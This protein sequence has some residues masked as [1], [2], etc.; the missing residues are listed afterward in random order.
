MTNLLSFRTDYSDPNVPNNLIG[1]EAYGRARES[2]LTA[3]Q[4]YDL[5]SQQKLQLGSRLGPKILDDILLDVTTGFQDQYDSLN[6]QIDQQASTF[7]ATQSSY[8][9]QL[10]QQR[11]QAAQLQSQFTN[12]QRAQ[13]PQ[14][15]KTAKEN[16]AEGS[17]ATPKRQSGLS[18]L[19]IVSGLGTQANPLSGLQ[20]A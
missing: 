14:A 17:T 7:R 3:Q 19:A 12:L 9:N 4:V 5:A 11:A 8:Q 18:S 16:R 15:E 6:N 1:L 10:S 20:L 13:I 2:G